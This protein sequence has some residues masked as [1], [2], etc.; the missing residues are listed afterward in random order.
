MPT[1]ENHPVRRILRP[2]PALVAHLVEKRLEVAALALRHLQADQ[3]QSDSTPPS[4]V[5]SI[6]LGWSPLVSRPTR[7]PPGTAPG[8]QRTPDKCA[9]CSHRHAEAQ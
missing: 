8:R 9:G 7:A 1:P 3:H 5:C 2:V 6:R 4:T